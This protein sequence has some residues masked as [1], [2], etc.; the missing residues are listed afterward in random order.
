VPPSHGCRPCI[1]TASGHAILPS[2]GAAPD[3]PMNRPLVLSDPDTH[4]RGREPC[5]STVGI[6]PTGLHRFMTHHHQVVKGSRREEKKK[7]TSAKSRWSPAPLG[8]QRYIGQQRSLL[9]HKADPKDCWHHG[10]PPCRQPRRPL[11]SPRRDRRRHSL[12]A[13]QALRARGRY[14]I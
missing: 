13:T 6:V 14:E 5:A 3:Q 10:P 7:M 12:Q 2:V 9:V 1:T 4:P 8:H 11:P